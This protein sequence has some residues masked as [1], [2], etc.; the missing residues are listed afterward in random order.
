MTKKADKKGGQ[1]SSE[2][3]YDTIT[4]GRVKKYLRDH[5]SRILVVVFGE[6]D[7]HGH[8]KRYELYLKEAH[9]ADSRIA[10]LWTLVQDDPYYKDQTNFLI[11]TDHG[12]GSKTTNWY[13]HGLFVKGSSQTWIGLIGPHI[14]SLKLGKQQFYSK[15][16]A[17][18]IASLV[19]EE[20][21]V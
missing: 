6:G 1:R 17:G 12:R 11:T 13:D 4:Y 14:Q 15:E 10:E 8:Q 21:S 5:H 16:L 9:K 19:G 7:L 3:R 18:I 20:F 2:T